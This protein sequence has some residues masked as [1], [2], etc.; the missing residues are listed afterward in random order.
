MRFQEQ[1]ARLWRSFIHAFFLYR[2]AAVRGSKPRVTITLQEALAGLSHEAD[3]LAQ[4]FGND[5]FPRGPE[6][7]RQFIRNLQKLA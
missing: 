2:I 5:V 3:A 4:G 6:R 1:W 7:A